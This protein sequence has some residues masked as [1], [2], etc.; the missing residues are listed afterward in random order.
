MTR[1]E[2]VMDVM[3]VTRGCADWPLLVEEWLQDARETGRVPGDILG[4]VP[5]RVLVSVGGTDADQG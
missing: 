4:L 1:K 3:M 2:S 5:D